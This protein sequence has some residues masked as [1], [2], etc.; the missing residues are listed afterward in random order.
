MNLQKL[1]NRVRSLTR[2]GIVCSTDVSWLEMPHVL[3]F[4]FSCLLEYC[5]CFQTPFWV[6]PVGCPDSCTVPKHC[7]EKWHMM[8]AKG[9]L[10]QFWVS[11]SVN[12]QNWV[13][14]MASWHEL[15]NSSSIN[16]NAD[17]AIDSNAPFF[18]F[19]R[20]IWISTVENWS[21]PFNGFQ[22][23]GNLIPQADESNSLNR[24]ILTKL[25]RSPHEFFLIQEDQTSFWVIQRAL[26]GF[27]S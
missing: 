12:G 6:Q 14:E 27:I 7:L 13:A 19:P 11:T 22:M 4:K 20:E 8:W 9:F 3:T 24:V 1:C 26:W 21:W 17:I 2:P 10:G 25:Q 15:I 5:I 16:K 18:P 23:S